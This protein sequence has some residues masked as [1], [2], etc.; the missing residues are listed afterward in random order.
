MAKL[1]EA[2]IVGRINSIKK[3]LD[4]DANDLKQ[5]CQTRADGIP[6]IAAKIKRNSGLL[7]EW[8]ERLQS[9]KEQG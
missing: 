8:L 4:S 9:L 5:A 6:E 2:H 3:D 7:I 1:T